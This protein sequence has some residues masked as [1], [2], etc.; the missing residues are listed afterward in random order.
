M[1][2]S[3]SE[4]YGQ[5]KVAETAGGK[6]L[7]KVYVKVYAQM[8]DG[9]ESST[10]YITM[11]ATNLPAPAELR[12]ELLYS[13]DHGAPRRMRDVGIRTLAGPL[14]APLAVAA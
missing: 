13:R 9:Q 12:P 8:A 10:R 2:V 14:P 3:L 1:T 5:L 4:N 6:A 7:G 11:A